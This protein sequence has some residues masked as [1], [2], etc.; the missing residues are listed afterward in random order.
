MERHVK[1]CKCQRC[2]NKRVANFNL[3][4]TLLRDMV[5]IQNGNITDDISVTVTY[6]T[7]LLDSLSVDWIE[8]EELPR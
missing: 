6:A 1:F 8:H 4:K 7:E 5:D 2:E 3:L